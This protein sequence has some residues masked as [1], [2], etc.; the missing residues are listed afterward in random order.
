M[1]RFLQRVTCQHV[2]TWSERRQA[3]RCYRC[4]ATRKAAP[5]E[6]FASGLAPPE[7]EPEPE[8]APVATT[9]VV[10]RTRRRAATRPAGP[11]AEA[12]TDGV[13]PASESTAPE[14]AGETAEEPH[15]EHVP[16]K[17]KGG[18]RKR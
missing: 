13:A 14:A 8:P 18:S 1:L 11:P 7:P 2:W 12:P 5:P 3:E 15:V 4:R 16:I 6:A 9:T 10:T 17:R